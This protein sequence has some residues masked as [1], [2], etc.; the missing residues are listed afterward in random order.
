MAHLEIRPRSGAT[1]VRSLDRKSPVTIGSSP[2]ADVRLSAT[3]VQAIECR[4]L[5]NGSDYQQIGRAHV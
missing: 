5:W 3:G 2:A 4:I 1:D